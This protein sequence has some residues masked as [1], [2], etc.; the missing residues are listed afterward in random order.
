MFKIMC[1][2]ILS[3]SLN[4]VL[5]HGIL[6]ACTCLTSEQAPREGLVLINAS[7]SNA[8]IRSFGWFCLFVCLLA[9][10]WWA[11]SYFFF[12]IVP[13]LALKK[14]HPSYSLLLIFQSE[15]DTYVSS[16]DV[17]VLNTELAVLFLLWGDGRLFPLLLLSDIF[18]VFSLGFKLRDYLPVSRVLLCI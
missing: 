7:Q 12:S 9:S 1:F 13:S 2:T 18:L 16:F 8:K 15:T 3:W 6:W 4:L 5:A 17:M 14:K 10:F 11:Y